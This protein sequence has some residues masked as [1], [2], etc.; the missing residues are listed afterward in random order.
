MAIAQRD[1]GQDLR[2]FFRQRLY[3]PGTPPAFAA[4]TPGVAKD[5]TTSTTA[6]VISTA[7]NAALTVSDPGHLMNGTDALRTGSYSKTLTFTLSTTQP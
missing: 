6:N 7:E 5:Y 3:T 2:D 4:F 1:S